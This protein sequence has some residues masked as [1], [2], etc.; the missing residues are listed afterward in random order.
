MYLYIFFCLHTKFVNV[1]NICLPLP[2]A[3]MN[4]FIIKVEKPKDKA[5]GQQ[6]KSK[7]KNCN[8][9]SA[10]KPQVALRQTPMWYKRA[11]VCSDC[12]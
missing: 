10:E 6:R 9:L 3:T 1:Q 8:Y 5:S 7:N 11:P 12:S 4:I 2:K